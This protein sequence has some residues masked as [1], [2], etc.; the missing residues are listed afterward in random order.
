MESEFQP[1]TRVKRT[2]SEAQKENLKKGRERLMTMRRGDEYKERVKKRRE[3][4]VKAKRSGSAGS[5]GGRRKKGGRRVTQGDIKKA[6]KAIS[7]TSMSSPA[8]IP[9]VAQQQQQQQQQ[10]GLGLHGP[11]AMFSD[12]VPTQAA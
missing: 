8:T 2:L 10:L 4:T 1:K 3:E 6:A 5:D 11:I 9:A 12:N 7:A